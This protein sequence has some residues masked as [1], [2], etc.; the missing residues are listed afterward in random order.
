MQRQ[1]L[2][3]D[4]FLETTNYKHTTV[5]NM[6]QT[7]AYLAFLRSKGHPVP[8]YITKKPKKSTAPPKPAKPAAKPQTSSV[9]PVVTSDTAALL[10]GVEY[11]RYAQNGRLD[12]LPGCHKDM[13]VI[14]T[15]LTNL[16]GLAS[17]DMRVLMDDG[18]HTI[19]TGAAIRAG[20]L[21]LKSQKKQKLWIFYSGH[22]SSITDTNGDEIDGQ[23]E[24]LVPEDFLENGFIADD[25]MASFLQTVPAETQSVTCVFDCCHSGSL[26]DMPYFFTTKDNMAVA[27]TAKSGDAISEPV[28]SAKVVC[29][30]ACADNQTSVSAYNLDRKRQWQGALTFGL[31]Q[32]VREMGGGKSAP[33]NAKTL[34]S[35]ISAI[36]TERD[37]EQTTTLAVP[38]STGS[39]SFPA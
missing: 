12:R 35:R 19:P 11:V 22:G 34:V 26:V 36:M 20:L 30:S 1:S 17:S 4:F 27:H 3:Y 23:D 14:Q 5:H 24:V 32:A 6:S 39:F 13:A 38:T 7:S 16:Y 33:I 18:S 29:I 37:F 31:D 21:W 25:E 28:S 10:I 15:L 9:A 2:G 8:A